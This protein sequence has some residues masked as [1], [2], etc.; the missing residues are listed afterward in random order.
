[1]YGVALTGKIPD[2]SQ[3]LRPHVE[4][5]VDSAAREVAMEMDLALKAVSLAILLSFRNV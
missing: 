2:V 5:V 3:D 4:G 1:V